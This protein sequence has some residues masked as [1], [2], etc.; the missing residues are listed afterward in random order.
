MSEFLRTCEH[1]DL[2]E[3]D[4]QRILQRIRTLVLNANGI[5]ISILPLHTMDWSDAMKSLVKD[6]TR[7]VEYYDGISIRAAHESYMLP[8]IVMT[9]DMKKPQ[10]KVELCDT[11]IFLRDNYQCQYCGEFFPKSNLSFDHWIPRKEGGKTTWTNI[12]TACRPCNHRKGTQ[13]QTRWQPRQL[14]KKPDR[15]ILEQ[16]AR[17]RPIV[18]PDAAWIPYLS[19]KAPVQVS[20]TFMSSFRDTEIFIDEE[21]LSE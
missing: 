10:Y 21:E 20:Q 1:D 9:L 8:S 12:V 13:N 5:P 14:P 16:R 11:N 19:W 3:K 18:V 15:R 7:V 6:A 4:R 2:S 17:R